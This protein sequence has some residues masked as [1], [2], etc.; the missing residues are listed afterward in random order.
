METNG[1]LILE[2]LILIIGFIV[3]C[4]GVTQEA[5]SFLVLA[6]FILFSPIVISAW[7]MQSLQTELDKYQQTTI[8]KNRIYEYEISDNDTIPVDTIYAEGMSGR[9]YYYK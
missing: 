8:E 4:I 6:S 2:V 3:L 5:S 1:V 7:K 9:T